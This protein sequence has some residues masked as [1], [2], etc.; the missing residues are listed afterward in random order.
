MWPVPPTSVLASNAPGPRPAVEARGCLPAGASTG[1]AL[2]PLP[3]HT[4]HGRVQPKQA[5]GA[6][7]YH[8]KSNLAPARRDV[9]RSGPLEKGRLA[10]LKACAWTREESRLKHSDAESLEPALPVHTVTA[11]PRAGWPR[12]GLPPVPLTPPS[13]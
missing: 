9:A 5:M 10:G 2:H 3:S 12:L 8:K 6:N 13:P 11:V 7:S 1:L 4:G